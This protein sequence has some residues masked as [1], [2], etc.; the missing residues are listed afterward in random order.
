MLRNFGEVHAAGWGAELARGSEASPVPRDDAHAEDAF[1]VRRETDTSA[2][3][4]LPVQ[5]PR[6]GDQEREDVVVLVRL[7]RGAEPSEALVEQE[8]APVFDVGDVAEG[9][10]GAE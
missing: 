8:A 1:S 3:V 10:L 7:Q 6:F 4:E 2:S 9:E 5:L